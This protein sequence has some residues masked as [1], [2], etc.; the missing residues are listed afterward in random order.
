MEKRRGSMR[1]LAAEVAK[2]AAPALGRRGFASAQLIAEWPSVIGATLADKLAPDRL[3]F[4]RGE[5]QGGTLRLRVASGFATEAQHRTP[6]I[7]ERVNGFFGYAA[8]AR[9]VLVQGPLNRPGR[10]APPPPR[11]LA[12]AERAALD[13]TLAGIEDPDLRDALRRLGSAVIGS[14]KA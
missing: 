10:P 13:R 2:I 9:L 4:P 14:E 3:V 1:A 8:V 12:P 11:K 7:L 6:L 5:R